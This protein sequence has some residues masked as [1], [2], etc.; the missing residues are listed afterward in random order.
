MTYFVSISF[1]DI[2]IAWVPSTLTD[3]VKTELSMLACWSL[4]CVPLESITITANTQHNLIPWVCAFSKKA[5]WPS[6]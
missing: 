5:V 1:K 6:G 3:H 2:Y 4:H